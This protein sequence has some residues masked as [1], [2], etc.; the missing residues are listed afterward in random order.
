LNLTGIGDYRLHI[1][2]RIFCDDELAAVNKI[3][4]FN[5]DGLYQEIIVNITSF[6]GNTPP[7]WYKLPDVYIHEDMVIKDW[8]DLRDYVIDMDDIIE[9][10]TFSIVTVS[11][12]AYITIAIDPEGVVDILP[13]PDFDGIS[14]VTLRAEDDEHYSST[15]TFTVYMI[16]KN[17][18][19]T[20]SILKP[21]AREIVA[22]KV[23][24]EGSAYDIEDDLELIQLKFGDESDDWV[25]AEGLTFWEFVWDTHIFAPDTPEF[26]T[27][28]ARAYDGQN[29]SEFA[30]LELVV[31]NQN[32]DADDD[33]YP[34]T[35]DMF[36]NDPS[37]WTDSDG[38]GHGDNKDAF[39]KN[40]TE[41]VDSDGDGR[42]DN[43]DAFPLLGT[44][45]VDNDGD[46]HGD[47]SDLFPDDPGR[48]TTSD[49]A[50]GPDETDDGS[51]VEYLWF[52]IAIIVIINILTFLFYIMAR[53]KE[54]NLKNKKP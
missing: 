19:P 53:R 48:H 44:E 2:V 50:S 45:W 16:P 20:I 18:V 17:D 6:G 7:I 27:V 8:Q 26:V 41:W 13:N 4:N 5:Y 14:Q 46:G 30:T 35:E 36:P 34:N 51:M 11:N 10:L 22:G 52:F 12:S 29:Y 15:Q 49:Q 25:E 24:I 42:G 54:K 47:N 38:D 23:I 33:G 32:I 40:A 21:N 31:N 43:S 1:P 3:T 9:N 28:S 39:P 37:E